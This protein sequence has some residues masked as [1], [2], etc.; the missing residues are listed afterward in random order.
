MRTGRAVHVLFEFLSND[1]GRGDLAEEEG[2]ANTT[3]LPQH[4]FGLQRDARLSSCIQF[5][6]L[7]RHGEEKK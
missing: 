7:L 6:R 3:L 1:G 5:R 4:N 2:L